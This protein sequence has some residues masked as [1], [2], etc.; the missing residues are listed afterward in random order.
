MGDNRHLTFFEMLGNWSLGDYFK[1]EAIK[2]SFEFL[3][4]ELGIPAEKISVTCFEG[5]RENNIPR[6]DESAEI[7]KSLG[8]P[9]ERIKFLGRAD[10]WWGPAGETGPC[11]PDTE[12]FVDGVEI[13]NNV[14]IQ[15][16]KTKEGQFEPLEWTLIS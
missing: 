3:T 16:N 4:K 5:D 2:W 1:T 7:W 8:I 13:W 12:I 9:E 14:F 10:N 11:G 6:D 15:Y